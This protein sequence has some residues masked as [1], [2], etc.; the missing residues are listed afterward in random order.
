M[1]LDQGNEMII[2]ESVLTSF[3]ARFIFEAKI[4]LSL[5]LY[6]HTYI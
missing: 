6:H 1:D 2:F 4:G 5:K 3:E